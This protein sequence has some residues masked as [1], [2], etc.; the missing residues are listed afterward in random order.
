MSEIFCEVVAALDA[1]PLID[2]VGIIMG[3]PPPVVVLEQ[4]KL[5]LSA[6]ALRPLF[7]YAAAEFQTAAA[8]LRE[9]PE[10]EA[11][12]DSDGNSFRQDCIHALNLSKAVLLVKGDIAM[13]INF[14]KEMIVEGITT[15][16][17]ELRFIAVLFTRHPKSPGGWQHR[18]WCLQRMLLDGQPL[19]VERELEL[20]SRMAELY[21]KNYYAWNHRLWVL[22]HMSAPQ[23][24]LP[25]PILPY[26]ILSYLTAIGLGLGPGPLQDMY[27]YTS[28]GTSTVFII[29]RILIANIIA[30]QHVCSNDMIYIYIS[31][32]TSIQLASE[33]AFCR[34]WLY[35]HVSDHSAASHGVQVMRQRCLL[36][37]GELEEIPFLIFSVNNIISALS[38]NQELIQQR[39]GSEALWCQRRAIFRVLADTLRSLTRLP[40]RLQ[41]AAPPPASASGSDWPAAAAIDWT[42]GS[43]SSSSS[44]SSGSNGS[45][46]SGSS[47]DGSMSMAA[48]V[49]AEAFLGRLLLGE[50][51]FCAARCAERGAWSYP[52]QRRHAL[53]YLLYI[54]HSV[55]GHGISA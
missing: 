2:E 31:T 30:M 47:A 52:A 8:R 41:G 40:Q 13:V 24:T 38:T 51:G 9:R 36:R 15:C 11:A 1:D 28:Y 54:L 33:T 37:Q 12:A 39:P 20:C 26:L 17:D 19:D 46:G 5:G 53:R 14:R 3:K 4:H 49:S 50:Q 48:D 44:S 55:G 45:S 35:A 42:C 29:F 34:D 18:R 22:S 32:S 21:P 25:Y 7:A 16:A 43:S 6:G 23:V 10:A 27:T